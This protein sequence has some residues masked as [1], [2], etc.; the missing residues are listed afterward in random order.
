MAKH[1]VVQDYLKEH[2]L[3]ESNIISFNN[4]ID[5]KMQQIVNELND[6]LAENEN[7]V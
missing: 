6:S 1:I 5:E 2:S 3:V 4:F 7:D